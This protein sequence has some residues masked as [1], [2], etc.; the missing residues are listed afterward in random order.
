MYTVIVMDLLAQFLTL[1]RRR[2]LIHIDF[3]NSVF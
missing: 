1:Y 3:R 2:I